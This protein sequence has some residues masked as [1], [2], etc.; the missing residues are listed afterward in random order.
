M[1]DWDN[2][3]NEFL[4]FRQREI[5]EGKGKISREEMERKVLK[6]YAI[7]NTRRLKTPPKDEIEAELPII[8]E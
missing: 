5:L 2:S 1:S 4:K 8:K 6:E 3:L 7:Y